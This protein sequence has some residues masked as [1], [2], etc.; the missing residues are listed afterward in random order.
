M[1]FI[2]YNQ[3][4]K[5]LH[6]NLQNALLKQFKQPLGGISASA[7]SINHINPTNLESKSE[8]VLKEKPEVLRQSYRK[9]I[10]LTPLNTRNEF[11]DFQS[12]Y[13]L[14]N[15]KMLKMQPKV[16]ATLLQESI[17]LDMNN[18]NNNNNNSIFSNVTVAG[19]G[20][21]NFTLSNGQL[22]HFIQDMYNNIS[23]N[24]NSSSSSSS[25]VFE[26]GQDRQHIVVDYSSPNIAKEM[27]VVCVCVYVC[28]Y[29][30]M[31]VCVCV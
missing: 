2:K 1:T 15:A 26:E 6:N 12:N 28:V 10:Q 27:H 24:N 31:Y 7:G 14:A 5:C 13:A 21:I 19:S 23:G 4:R 9:Y 29:V 30:Y 17:L 16:L 8:S 18:N 22:E 25:S 11:G 3:L 20:Y